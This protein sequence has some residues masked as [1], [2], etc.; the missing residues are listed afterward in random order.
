MASGSTHADNVA[1][2]LY[3]GMVAAMRSEHNRFLVH[4]LPIPQ[5]LTV[6]ILHPKIEINTK[7]ARA[8][9]KPQVSLQDHISQSMLL[10]QFLMALYNE[11]LD[12]LAGSSRDLIIE[13]QRKSLIPGFDRLQANAM[14]V[15]ALGYTIS[16]AG[17]SMFGLF[18]SQADAQRFADLLPEFSLPY[19]FNSWITSISP[20]G[21][22]VTDVENE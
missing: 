1:A 5:D 8:I 14:E 13:P 9:I 4:P 2:S 12:L 17:P 3:G 16:G 19:D 6:F 15:G 10:T 21:A 18:E 22:H 11:D 20:R 7:D